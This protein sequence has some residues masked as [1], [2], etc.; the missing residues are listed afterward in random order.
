MYT[1]MTPKNQQTKSLQEEHDMV[2]YPL[3]IT[4][5]QLVALF[6]TPQQKSTYEKTHRLLANTKAS[7]LREAALHCLVSQR[8]RFTYTIHKKYSTPL[9]DFVSQKSFQTYPHIYQLILNTIQQN[10][11]QTPD[12]QP[13]DTTTPYIFS[14]QAIHNL[15]LPMEIVHRVK[16]NIADTSYIF[17]IQQHIINNILSSTFQLISNMANTALAN[18]QSVDAITVTD[19]YLIRHVADSSIED[20]NYCVATP[21]TI[22]TAEEIATIESI[23]LEVRT[24]LNISPKESYFSAHASDFRRRTTKLLRRAG[25][26]SYQKVSLLTQGST[27]TSLYD[28][29]ISAEY[30][31][32]ATQDTPQSEINKIL[33][34]MLENQASLID[35]HYTKQT[36]KRNALCILKLILQRFT[37]GKVTKKPY[38][39]ETLDTLMLL[40]SKRHQLASSTN[41]SLWITTTPT[42]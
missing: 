10:P 42:P 20:I 16:N 37:I 17:G 38:Q 35:S 23:L 28:S 39:K 30:F 32:P 31:T 27:Y 36:D 2:S 12:T 29:L 1:F 9:P 3:N 13:T 33:D 40:P 15:I 26:F 6:G 4:T 24:E 7:I 22:A 21:Y 19:S 5:A 8:D 34:Y 18:L 41:G 11:T 25:I 14:P